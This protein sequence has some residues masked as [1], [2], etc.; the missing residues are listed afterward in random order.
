MC[1]LEPQ[2]LSPPSTE[3]K[4]PSASPTSHCTGFS[5]KIMKWEP[6]LPSYYDPKST[7]SNQSIFSSTTKLL[8]LFPTSNLASMPRN[9]APAGS[10][11]SNYSLYKVSI[12]IYIPNSNGL[13]L[14][15]LFPLFWC[16]RPY[17][18]HIS[19]KILI[20]SSFSIH[21]TYFLEFSSILLAV[22]LQSPLWVLFLPFPS[23][24]RTQE[25]SFGLS[26]SSIF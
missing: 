10:F 16:I 15:P 12:N 7:L 13:L 26:P 1:V 6:A 19:F 4:V 17:W 14:F 8:E 5:S 21:D 23:F 3:S 24:A 25:H 11:Y 20:D 22:Y 18:W 2:I 9:I